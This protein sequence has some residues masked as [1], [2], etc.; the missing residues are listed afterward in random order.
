MRIPP[1]TNVPL[2]DRVRRL[3][4]TPQFRRLAGVSQLGLVRFVYPGATHSRFEHSLGAFRM[5]LLFADRLAEDERFCQTVSARHC[6]L[7]LAAALLH[8]IAHWPYCHPVEDIELP[9]IPEHEELAAG[10]LAAEPL[11]TCLRDDW[12]IEPGDVARLLAGNTRGPAE[13]IVAS[14]LS[15]P[16]DIDKTDYLVRDSH[17]AGVPYG[18]NFDTHRLIQSLCLNEAGTGIAISDKG[19]TAAEMMVFARYVMFSEVYWHKAV[20]SATAMLQRV[21]YAL[22]ERLDWAEV[23]SSTDETIAGPLRNAATGSDVEGLCDGLFGSRRCLHKCLAQYSLFEEPEIYSRLSRKPY[24]WLVE[25]S[26]RIAERLR[27]PLGESV[28]PADFLLDAPPMGLEVDFHTE[29]FFRPDRRYRNLGEVSP[30][31]RALAKEQFDDYV[32]RVRVFVHPRL[33]ERL[34]KGGPLWGQLEAAITD[35][36]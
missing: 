23:F 17:H 35:G 4:D 3:I 26:G 21:F 12:G 29:V 11:A 10:I 8:D 31:V 15:G 24:A 6:E 13:G 2:T 33:A 19:K 1:E 7:F 22:A 25:L 14:M 9:G 16:I 34:Q 30:M 20:R 28:A 32:K 18:K 5:A 36:R 27:K